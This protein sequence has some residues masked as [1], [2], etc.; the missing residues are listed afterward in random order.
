M[1]TPFLQYRSGELALPVV[2]INAILQS[3]PYLQKRER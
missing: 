3:L 2:V 1:V